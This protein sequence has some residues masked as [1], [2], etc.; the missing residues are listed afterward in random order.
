MKAIMPEVDPTL[1]EMDVSHYKTL[2]KL[3]MD[4]ETRTAIERLL[5]EAGRNLVRA[6]LLKKSLAQAAARQ[7]T[8]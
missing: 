3:N 2:L 1:I 5:G 8:T 6:K 4:A 7:C